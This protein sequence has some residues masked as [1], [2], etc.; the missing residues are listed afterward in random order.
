MDQYLGWDLEYLG[1]L[2]SIALARPFRS[3]MAYEVECAPKEHGKLL[4]KSCPVKC[5]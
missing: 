1:Y 3:L 4:G 5:T 2:N